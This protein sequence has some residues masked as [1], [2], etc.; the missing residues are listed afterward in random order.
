MR[1]RVPFVPPNNKARGLRKLKVK[2]KTYFCE[3]FGKPSQHPEF[4][5]YHQ[6]TFCGPD[7]KTLKF[8]HKML[9]KN[10]VHRFEAHAHCGNYQGKFKVLQISGTRVIIVRIFDLTID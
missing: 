1:V 3:S 6:S 10:K 9:K 4:G 2:G 7:E 5:D 8:F